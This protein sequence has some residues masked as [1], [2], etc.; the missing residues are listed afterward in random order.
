MSV[1]V[2]FGEIMGRM[3][4]PGFGRFSQ[5]LPGSVEM[6]FGGAESNVAV[7]ISQLGGQSRFVSALPDQAIGQACLDTLRRF[8]VDTDFVLMSSK[9]RLGLY[10]LETG[11]TQ[12]PSRVVYDR[13][14]SSVGITPFE[15]YDWDRAFDGAGWFHVTGITP[16]V[17]AEAADCA[18]CAAE[19]AKSRGLT[20]SCDLNFRKKLW[21]WEPGTEPKTLCRRVMAELLPFVD[22][23]IANEQDAEDV[24]D[25]R[26]G[27]SDVESGKLDVSHYPDTA[28]QIV[29]RFPNVSHVAITL[30]ESISASH[31]NWAAMLYVAGSSQAVFE[32]S[33][34][35]KLD[36]YEITHIVD[37]VGGGDAFGA[38]LIHAMHCQG[39]SDQPSEA[40]AFAV[41]SSC[42]AH[43]MTGDFNLSTLEE[44]QA[45]A[46][47]GRSGR[48]VR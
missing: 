15:E 22:V 30:R 46:K 25:I 16:A 36:P 45:L 44:V 18:R 10:F 6:T 11:A 5:C 38:G 8:G 23:V 19:L 37:R 4:M 32:P 33:T 42:L 28:R 39:L 1:V 2:C 17:S 7:S 13:D 26:A 47:G 27:A 21:K 34:E 9:G 12:R 24:L 31:N 41:A 35:G 20:V 14:G 29:E 43:T 40:L 3:A 48:V